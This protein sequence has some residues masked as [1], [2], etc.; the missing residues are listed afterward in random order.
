MPVLAAMVVL[1]SSS[2][3]R[4]EYGLDRG[5]DATMQLGGDSLYLPLGTTV[6]FTVDSLLK[7][8]AVAGI[9]T[10]N[11]QGIYVLSPA[12]ISVSEKIEGVPLEDLVLDSV[13][14]RQD[15]PVNLVS[16]GSASK[17]ARMTASVYQEIGLDFE[18]EN[19]SDV[20]VELENMQFGSGTRFSFDLRFSSI[21]AGIDLSSLE[22]D[23]ML[24]FP[25]IF[26]FNGDLLLP[27]NQIAITEFDAASGGFSV[28]LPLEGLDLSLI[29][30]VDHNLDFT[31]LIKLSGTISFNPL[32]DGGKLPAASGEGTLPEG[33]ELAASVVC[34]A[35]DIAPERI[36]GV[37]SAKMPEQ[38]LSLSF[39]QLPPLMQSS[40]TVLDLENPRVVVDLAT[41][42]GIPMNGSLELLPV[43]NGMRDFSAREEVAIRI[44][45][46]SSEQMH[47]FSFWIAKD[48]SGMPDGAIFCEA[49]L[50][51]LLRRIPDSLVVV[52][53]AVSDTTQLHEY[54]FDR[55][56]VVEGSVQ[57]E[58]PLVFG[59]DLAVAYEDT[60]SGL[61]DNFVSFVEGKEMEILAEIDNRFPLDI[62][63]R[64][65]L[66]DENGAVVPVVA[67]GEQL[68]RACEKEGEPQVSS[69]SFLFSDLEGLL[70]GKQVKSLRLG[71]SVQSS[72]VSA[73]I[74]VSSLSSIQAKL[75]ARVEGGFTV[76]LNQEDGEPDSE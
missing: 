74:P 69:V 49:D 9:L 29:D 8:S 16:A 64:L 11:P 17:A 44:P 42:L 73:G 51:S 66:L 58:V 4:D 39:G 52:V 71:C 47:R 70:E 23:L 36:Q 25:D 63:I 57:P 67:S 45:G 37:F 6:P 61:P 41:N 22:P 24:E 60:L 53:N 43:Y 50:S 31:A 13:G 72:E 20:V 5:I 28:E 76:D 46:G 26:L 19:I 56:P 27:G 40:S 32:A 10:V 18:F 7:E 12:A 35:L 1:L 54:S 34:A 59:S 65:D 68:I 2:C 75:K 55:D 15:F 14:T 62:H 30:L 48:A 33:Q 21:P 38:D 3:R